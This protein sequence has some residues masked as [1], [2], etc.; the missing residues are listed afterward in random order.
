MRVSAPSSASG[1][2]SVESLDKNPGAPSSP[3]RI[4]TQRREHRRLNLVFEGSTPQKFTCGFETSRQRSRPSQIWT[5]QTYGWSPMQ[6]RGDCGL[7]LRSIRGGDAVVGPDLH[8]PHSEPRLRADIQG[9]HTIS[10]RESCIHNRPSIGEAFYAPTRRS[11][12][13]SWSVRAVDRKIEPYCMYLYRIFS[14]L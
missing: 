5:A 8:L 9:R 14:G 3:G 13:R 11:F 10:M 12:A 2:L 4:E 7:D 1:S 6:L